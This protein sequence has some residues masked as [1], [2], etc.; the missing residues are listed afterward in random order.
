MHR[1]T[2]M[3]CRQW[4]SC[5][6]ERRCVLK[7]CPGPGSGIRTN[8]RRLIAVVPDNLPALQPW[9]TQTASPSV[10]EPSVSFATWSG[11]APATVNVR[12]GQRNYRECRVS[13]RAAHLA[14]CWQSHVAAGSPAQQTFVHQS[15]LPQV[16]AIVCGQACRS[17]EEEELPARQTPPEPCSQEAVRLASCEETQ[18]LKLLCWQGQYRQQAACRWTACHEERP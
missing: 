12:P 17:A 15:K 9:E 6:F 13:Q 4:Q 2:G 1:G 7:V 8:S 5:W 14:I 11:L 18:C 10:I 16:P 3:T